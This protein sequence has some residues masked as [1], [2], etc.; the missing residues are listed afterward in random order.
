MVAR[1]DVYR[2]FFIP[3]GAIV[4]TI[5]YAMF[6]DEKLYP[7]PEAFNPGGWLDPSYPTFKGL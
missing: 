1:D 4:H 2:G 3:K 6:Q 5:Q 7:D